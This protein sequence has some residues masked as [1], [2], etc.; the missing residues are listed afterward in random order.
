MSDLFQ[1]SADFYAQ[2]PSPIVRDAE[3]TR[4]EAEVREILQN[5]T[6]LGDTERKN[7]PR[8]LPFFGTKSLRNLRDSLLRQ[9]LRTLIAAQK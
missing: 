6:F 7:L 5:S 8:L 2:F 4:M 1:L 9:N 3:G